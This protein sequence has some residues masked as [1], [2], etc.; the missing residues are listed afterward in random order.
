M[1]LFEFQLAD[2]A[3]VRPWGEAP[4]QS[5]SWFAL[6]DGVFHMPVGDQVLFRYSEEFNLLS[7]DA[8]YQLASIARD[9]FGSFA[10]GIARLPPALEALAA[11]WPSLRRLYQASYPASAQEDDVAYD[12][13]RWLGERSPWTSYFVANPDLNFVRVG[14][15]V[16]IHWDNR[17]RKIDGVQAWTA[18]HGVH[19]LSVSEFEAECR[20]FAD[21]LLGQMTVRIDQIESGQARPQIP[22]DVADLRS[23]HATW[24]KEFDSYFKPAEPDIPWEQTM[25]AITQIAKRAGIALP[26]GW[27]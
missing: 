11:D 12:A 8:D 7:R 18:L 21:R 22:L 13:W 5:L 9:V 25:A 14:E 1:A 15:G 4:K 24:V 3:K 23:Q 17:D 27:E 10:P 2:V 6:T 20:D 19:R 16:H 26:S